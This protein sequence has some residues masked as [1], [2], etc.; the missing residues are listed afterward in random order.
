M[1]SIQATPTLAGGLDSQ[2]PTLGGRPM[3]ALDIQ[4]GWF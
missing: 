1:D 2:M 3:Q 4:R